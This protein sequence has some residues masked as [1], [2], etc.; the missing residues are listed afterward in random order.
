M[1]P[2]PALLLRVIAGV[3]VGAAAWPALHA[4]LPRLPE[5]I[6]FLLGWWIFTF[7][8][9]LAVSGRLTADLDPLRR[10]II[11]LGVG[12]A[13]SAVLIDL[14]GRLHLIPLFPYAAAA[15]MG[16][17]LACWSAFAPA[18]GP[19]LPPSRDA[20]NALRRT[21][22]RGRLR[23]ERGDLMAA[24]ALLLLA[25]G[26]GAIV[27]SQRMATCCSMRLAMSKPGVDASPPC[28][29]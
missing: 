2:V 19:E 4:V 22:R 17:G 3:L 8:P 9:G 5:L 27:F 14:L 13:A 12:S 25:A 1:L 11:A 15:M 29:S 24:A 20:G 10:T 6:R 21:G 28:R 7:G 18:I 16:A 26:I 23:T